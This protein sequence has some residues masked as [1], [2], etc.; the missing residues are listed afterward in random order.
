[1][2]NKKMI[3]VTFQR[4]GIHRY[5]DAPDDVGYLANNHRHQFKF[6]V[7][8][9]VFHMNRELEFHQLVSRQ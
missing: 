1:M 6:K 7:S 4:A 5:P 8:I 9:E 2:A 3:W